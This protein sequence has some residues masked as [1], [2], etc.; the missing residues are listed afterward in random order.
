MTIHEGDRLAM[1]DRD[2]V[3]RVSRDSAQ[4]L[5]GV[6]EGPPARQGC[7][8][9]RSGAAGAHL[10]QEQLRTRGRP[11]AVATAGEGRAHAHL[12]AVRQ[13]RRADVRQL[14]EVVPA[15]GHACAPDQASSTAASLAHPVRPGLPPAELRD[16]CAARH[17][18]R[19]M[20]AEP[21]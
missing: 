20:P 14:V 9:A 16:A 17:Y 2:L 3:S 10:Q 15:A 11:L 19:S 4:P 7:G 13:H 18:V 12:H 21:A 8:D 5:W 6:L 1:F